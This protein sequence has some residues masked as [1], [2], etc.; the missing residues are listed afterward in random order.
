MIGSN[1]PPGRYDARVAGRFGI[2]NPRAFVVGE[3]EEVLEKQSDSPESAMEVTLDTTVNGHAEAGGIDYFKFQAKAGQRVFAVCEAREIDSR[4]DASLMLHDAAGRELKQS[5]RGGVLEFAAPQD[6]AY[7]LKVFDFLYG[8]GSEYFYRLSLKTRDDT[9]RL[10]M[11]LHENENITPPCEIRGHFY[12]AGDID[13][14]S[15]AVKKGDVYWVEV[16]SQRLGFPT[17]L[18][19]VIQDQ[20]FNDTENVGGVEFK[21]GSLDPAGR[22]EAK[23]DGTCRI[24]VRDLF[25]RTASIPEHIYRLVVRKET[26]DFRLVAMPQGPPAKKDAR[27]AFVSSSVLRRGGTIPIKVI[28][29]R[30]DGLKEAISVRAAELPE[31][32][33][34]SELVIPGDKNI[35]TL[36]LTAAEGASN[37]AGNISIIGTAKPGART[38]EVATVIWNVPDY[39]TEPVRS[40]LTDAYALAVCDEPAPISIEPEAKVAE[41]PASGK[42]SISLNVTRRG[43]FNEAFKLKAH[44]LAA[45]ESL[46]ELDV[47]EK[48]TN[49]VV[50]L[51]L[52]QQKLSPGTH[53]FY[54]QG[55]TKGKYRSPLETDKNKTKDLTI[56]V[57]SAPIVVKVSPPQTASK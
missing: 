18:L 51:D 37:W 45:V 44:G 48:G 38:A 46:K 53:S 8:G 14:Y 50:E 2:S 54:L 1:V 31:G 56:T 7:V 41:V 12:P 25:N 15:F 23:E 26:P 16:F 34:S 57:Y 24:Q 29:V 22:F 33:S 39:N 17:D 52:A 42:V 6:G 13:T 43:D 35:G 55:Q 5:R 11:L 47:K 10:G 49:A 3:L 40:R 28:A 19:L 20:E 21:T 30:R 32:V 9:P 36:L 27:E 4:M